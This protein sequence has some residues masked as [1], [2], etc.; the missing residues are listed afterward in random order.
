MFL[1]AKICVSQ[2]T[3]MVCDSQKA[4]VA[5]LNFIVDDG[6]CLRKEDQRKDIIL[7]DVMHTSRLYIVQLKKCGG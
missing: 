7:R 4:A 1:E 3:G 6:A 5:L 2:T